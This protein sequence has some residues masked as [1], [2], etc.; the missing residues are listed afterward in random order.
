MWDIGKYFDISKSFDEN[1]DCDSPTGIV[2]DRNIFQ[3]RAEYINGG[4][5]VARTHTEFFCRF[6]IF[7]QIMLSLIAPNIR[8]FVLFLHS[9]TLTNECLNIFVQTNL[10]RTNV[11]IYSKKKNWYERMSEYIFVTNIFEY[12]NIRI[13][14]SHSGV[15]CA[16]R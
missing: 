15:N 6:L 4:V 9:N 16:F 1:L 13:Y 11:R 8:I 2:P 7:L 10:I 3:I 12:S 14:S 5:F